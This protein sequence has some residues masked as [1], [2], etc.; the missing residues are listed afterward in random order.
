MNGR[1][2]KITTNYKPFIVLFMHCSFK[3]PVIGCACFSDKNSMVEFLPLYGREN[4]SCK[5]TEKILMMLCTLKRTIYVHEISCFTA[6][7][8]Q[9]LNSSN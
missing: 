9:I 1:H 3:L 4:S 8:I 6:N 7:T 2:A 5:M